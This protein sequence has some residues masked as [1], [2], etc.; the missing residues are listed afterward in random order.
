MAQLMEFG[1][2][3]EKDKMQTKKREI[4]WERK[5]DKTMWLKTEAQVLLC[6]NQIAAEARVCGCL[7]WLFLTLSPSLGQT[8]AMQSTV[9]FGWFLPR[10]LCS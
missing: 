10:P 1:P 4:A 2:F 5:T 7:V 3:K 6:K 8:A 9:G